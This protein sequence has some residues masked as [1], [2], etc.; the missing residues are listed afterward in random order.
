MMRFSTSNVVK[1]RKN[2]NLFDNIQLHTHYLANNE[3]I[4]WN[5]LIFTAQNQN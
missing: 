2:A 3:C 1:N 5:V 4:L